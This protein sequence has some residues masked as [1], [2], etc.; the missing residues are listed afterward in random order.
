MAQ[1]PDGKTI[2]IV[3]KVSG[4][5]G[6]HGGAWK[7]AY[8]DF[9]TAMMALFLVL[10][11]VSSA[12]VTTKQAIASFFKRPGVFELGSGTP[13]EMGGAGILPD[14]FAPPAEKDSM[15]I[16]NKKMYNDDGETEEQT[17]G[18]SEEK[19]DFDQIAKEIEKAITEHQKEVSGL[20][21]NVTVKSDQQGLHLEIM[22]TPTAS[23]FKSGSA[24]IVPEAQAQ[25]L[26]IA[27]IL[28]KL[29][30]PIDIE[31]HTDALPFTGPN[32]KNYNNWDLSTERANAARRIFEDAGLSGKQIARVVG[33]ADQRLKDPE[34]PQAP[35]NRR[36]SV[37]MRF[38]EQAKKA[39]DSTGASE[40]KPVPIGTAG[41]VPVV[42]A[43]A[44]KPVTPAPSSL[45]TP[46]PTAPAPTDA[47]VTEAASS[48]EDVGKLIDDAI[49]T[50]DKEGLKVEFS[51]PRPEYDGPAETSTTSDRPVWQ[52]KDKIFDD[53][54][55][56]F[57]K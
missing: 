19:K 47:K 29:P 15:I 24:A 1:G 22:D 41:Q 17:A 30:N 26:R 33:Y 40:T 52:Q 46:E 34:N 10:W 11:L 14:A 42:P 4:H 38:T 54:N 9:V 31:G 39:L 35:G 27:E 5:G 25:L 12:S 57:G 2:I 51:A 28:N 3:K 49:K 13:L 45:F 44:A 18:K 23:M 8:A 53:N 37:S 21:G 7:V 56:F 20:I 16:Q 32:S 6:H 43:E 50:G 48:R 36:I 55:P